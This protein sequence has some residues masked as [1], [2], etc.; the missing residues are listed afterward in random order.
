MY[1][2]ISTEIFSQLPFT[3]KRNEIPLENSCAWKFHRANTILF[4]C[5][6]DERENSENDTKQ[7][8]KQ[9]WNSILSE[10][11]MCSAYTIEYRMKILSY[12]YIVEKQKKE[13]Q[14][15]SSLI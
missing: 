12:K 1:A 7:I 8:S 4:L 2:T 14:L 13:K 9:S 15:S 6:M 5:G 10:E 3:Q 11:C